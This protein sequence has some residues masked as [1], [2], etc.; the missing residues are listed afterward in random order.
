MHSTSTRP[1]LLYPKLWFRSGTVT[2]GQSMLVPVWWS[3]PQDDW[4]SYKEL[5]HEKIAVAP[6]WKLYLWLIVNDHD[7]EV[8]SETKLAF[9]VVESLFRFVLSC[10]EF[11][12]S[13]Y[14]IILSW[15]GPIRLVDFPDRLI[16]N[17]FVSSAP[18]IVLSWSDLLPP[19][20]SHRLV[21]P[22]HHASLLFDSSS[23]EFVSSN[24][25]KIAEMITF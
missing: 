7:Y 1:L 4:K 20:S 13:T 22:T 2:L 23:A 12:S 18:Q 14:Q 6:I 21:R 16:A 3:M 8:R 15:I 25:A 17:K 24:S 5:S 19:S 11:V 9:W 10:T